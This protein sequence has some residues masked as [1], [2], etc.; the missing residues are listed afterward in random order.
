MSRACNRWVYVNEDDNVAHKNPDVSKPRGR[1]ASK[2]LV[3]AL[4]GAWNSCPG[5]DTV[6]L[7]EERR[8]LINRR[9]F[10]PQRRD[11]PVLVR[12]LQEI[13]RANGWR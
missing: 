13:E 4:R 5:I 7:T 1:A 10:V 12:L 2:A 8:R 6:L 3:D 9:L 11:S